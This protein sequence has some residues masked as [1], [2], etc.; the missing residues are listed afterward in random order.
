MCKKVRQI[1]LALAICIVSSLGVSAQQPG[2]YSMYMLNKYHLNPA[3]AGM[4]Y[5][6]SVNAIVRNQWQAIPGQPSSQMVNFHLPVYILNGAAGVK[7]ENERIGAELQ[8]KV[9]GSYSYVLETGIGLFNFGLQVGGIQKRLNGAILRTPEG[10]YEG[11]Q[12]DH[13]DPLLLSSNQQ[14]VGVLYGF[15]IY[16]IGDYLEGGISAEHIPVNNI[17]ISPAKIRLTP[18]I[19]GYL[20]TAI[21]VGE[22]LN[23]IPSLWVRSDLKQTQ[24]NISVLLKH[25]GNIF[26][27]VGMRG[28]SGKTLDSMHAILGW[29]FNE[30]YSLSY[31]YDIGLSSLRSVHEGSHEILFNYNLNKLIGAGLPPKIIY[32]PRHM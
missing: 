28:Y 1:F 10:N 25:R 24:G 8:L 15:G 30:N 26:G 13:Q 29:T 20:E 31:S 17:S 2:S 4:D 12:I 27:G 6:L 22:N 21:P 3:Y 11:G 7:V 16:Y 32:G 18:S 23:V 5:S 9:S 14:G 19:N